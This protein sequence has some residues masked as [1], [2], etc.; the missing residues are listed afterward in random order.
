MKMNSRGYTKD[1]VIIKDAKSPCLMVLTRE[2]DESELECMGLLHV[3]GSDVW[4][5]DYDTFMDAGFSDEHQIVPIGLDEGK[6]KAVRD[7]WIV[8]EGIEEYSEA[9]SAVARAEWRQ[10]FAI[11]WEYKTGHKLIFKEAE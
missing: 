6:G 11:L 4:C 1:S 9:P 10:M 7:A 3:V 5:T 8:F 2:N